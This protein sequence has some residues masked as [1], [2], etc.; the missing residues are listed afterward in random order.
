M[1]AKGT[2]A[3]RELRKAITHALKKATKSRDARIA[4]TGG[5]SFKAVARDPEVTQVLRCLCLST[6]AHTLIY[7]PAQRVLRGHT[8]TYTRS[9]AHSLR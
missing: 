5:T 2:K 3:L 1:A 8:L 4:S 6:H 9:L 7:A